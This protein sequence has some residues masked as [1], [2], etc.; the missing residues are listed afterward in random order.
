MPAV[1]LAVWL[2]VAACLFCR[3]VAGPAVR[4]PAFIWL[5]SALYPTDLLLLGSCSVHPGGRGPGQSSSNASLAR[6]SPPGP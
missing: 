4:L 3:G 5:G 1:V 2:F 6:P